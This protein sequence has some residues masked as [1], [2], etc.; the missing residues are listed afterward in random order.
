MGLRPCWVLL[1]LSP[2]LY[3]ETFTLNLIGTRDGNCW[4]GD[5]AGSGARPCTSED[6]IENMIRTAELEVTCHSSLMRIKAPTTLRYDRTA[7]VRTRYNGEL[8]DMPAHVLASTYS[9]L[10][11]TGIPLDHESRD[12]WLLEKL[13]DV[14]VG[15]PGN[16]DED[17]GGTAA[18][19]NAP[20]YSIPTACDPIETSEGPVKHPHYGV[21]TGR[22]PLVEFDVTRESL[23]EFLRQRAADRTAFD[24]NQ[25]GESESHALKIYLYDVRNPNVPK[26]KDREGRV[27]S[28]DLR[29]GYPNS[30]WQMIGT[31]DWRGIAVD[32]NYRGFRGTG[33]RFRETPA[34]LHNELNRLQ[35]F[36]E[37]CE[38]NFPAQSDVPSSPLGPA[39]LNAR[40]AVRSLRDATDEWDRWKAVTLEEF[41]DTP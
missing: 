16:S 26:M 4:A 41:A 38:A 5:G 35:D 32:S 23:W 36:Y 18:C 20:Y 29:H 37:V 15:G 13:V 40:D 31:V 39:A 24:T 3:A 17:P 33:I 6:S 10:L 11:S 34:A 19:G 9:P 21:G 27:R 30:S 2:A 28:T 12:T 7:M 1:V 25:S 8:V 14:W 22:W